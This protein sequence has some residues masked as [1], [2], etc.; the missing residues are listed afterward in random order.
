MDGQRQEPCGSVAAA[1][2]GVSGLPL[3]GKSSRAV[4]RRE[5]ERGRVPRRAAPAA[6]GPRRASARSDRHA[7]RVSFRL[8]ILYDYPTSPNCMKVRIL[9]RLLEVPHERVTVD[10]FRGETREA[11]H[12]ARNPDAR[13]PTL[14]LDDGT[15][16]AESGAILLY[17]AEGTRYLPRDPV[18]AAHCASSDVL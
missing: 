3:R 9:L 5:Q 12:L 4:V 13:V 2:H 17:L 15:P 8:V 18:G 1:T 10:V 6:V 11:A 14:E 16:I 7:G